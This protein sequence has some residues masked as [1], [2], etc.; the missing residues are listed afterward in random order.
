M[1]NVTGSPVQFLNYSLHPLKDK[2]IHSMS[3]WVRGDFLRSVNSSLEGAD[4]SLWAKTM[5]LAFKTS[6]SIDWTDEEYADVVCTKRGRA[7][8]L[9]LSLRGQAS[10]YECLEVFS[11]KDSAQLMDEFWL[12]FM[13][14]ND[15]S[16]TELEETEEKVEEKDFKSFEE[17]REEMYKSMKLPFNVLAEMT[18]TQLNKMRE[19]PDDI[20][21]AS[22]EELNRYLNGQ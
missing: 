19:L 9:S 3:L 4:K 12:L 11:G 7:M 15:M 2:Q 17:H 10:F 20:T 13:L 22:E 1:A 8:L 6:M 21:F 16:V 5:S 14:V 18:P